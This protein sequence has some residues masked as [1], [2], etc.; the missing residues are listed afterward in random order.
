MSGLLDAQIRKNRKSGSNW[1]L[2]RAA[3][4][5]GEA[6]SF[7]DPSLLFHFAFLDDR[8]A[9]SQ[10]RLIDAPAPCLFR[11]DPDICSSTNVSVAARDV[12]DSVNLHAAWRPWI[13]ALH[14]I[15]DQ[16]DLWIL[17]NVLELQSFREIES[18]NVEVLAVEIET[19]C[20]D[21]RLQLFRSGSDS[22]QP[23]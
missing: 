7:I 1:S 14:V 17:S 11:F 21:I 15:Y 2:L 18:A 6:I 13:D 22:C 12:S 3:G 23:L 10:G 5:T 4:A 9:L 16:R 20:S 8:L 19:H